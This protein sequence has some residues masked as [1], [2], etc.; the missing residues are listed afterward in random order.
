MLGVWYL[1]VSFGQLAGTSQ[2][3]LELTWQVCGTN[4]STLGS[5]RVCRR[6][7]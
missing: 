3:I 5:R 1:N 6:L 4:V 7:C 2:A